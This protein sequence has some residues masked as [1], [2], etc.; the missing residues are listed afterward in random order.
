M[1]R[2]VREPNLTTPQILRVS[3]SSATSSRHSSG[4][5]PSQPTFSK[6]ASKSRIPTASQSG[7]KKRA[8]LGERTDN[9]M[10]SESQQSCPASKP[11]P[12]GAGKTNLFNSPD[13]S[14][15]SLSRFIA[16]SPQT[17]ASI[18]PAYFP[19]S[20]PAASPNAT[21]NS[22]P[23][24]TPYRPRPSIT[25]NMDMMINDDDTLL[26]NMRPPEMD[27]A[28]PRLLELT[29]A[30]ED[31]TS[32]PRVRGGLMTP[33][34]SQEL[35]RGS[36]QLTQTVKR[37]PSATRLS[38]QIRDPVSRFPTPPSS[39]SDDTRMGHIPPATS[40]TTARAS[41]VRARPADTPPRRV[42]TEPSA[43]LGDISAE[44]DTPLRLGQDPSPNP[45]RKKSP[46][47][48]E[49]SGQARSP[50]PV[51]LRS[52]FEVRDRVEVVIP[53]RVRGLGTPKAAPTAITVK[54]KSKGRASTSRTPSATLSESTSTKGSTR[55]SSAGS[56]RRSSGGSQRSVT[57]ATPAQT[58]IRAIPATA[59]VKSRRR[60]TATPSVPNRS[61]SQT[62][63]TVQARSRRASTSATSK[64]P[65]G[66]NSKSVTPM[67]QAL[68]GRKLGFLPRPI[69]GSPGD[70]PL[71][72]KGLDDVRPGHEVRDGSGLGLD[73]NRESGLAHS[74]PSQT[75]AL[76]TGPTQTLSVSSFAS[77]SSPPLPNI[78]RSED[79]LT[80][81]RLADNSVGF[82]D[83]GP[84]WSDDGSDDEGVGEDTFVH[85]M[86]KRNVNST[87]RSNVE[88]TVVE[89][90]E[91]QQEKI[92]EE[93]VPR[94]SSPLLPPRVDVTER[95]SSEELGDITQDAESA[96][97]DTSVDVSE[98]PIVDEVSTDE[99]SVDTPIM[100][101]TND[102]VS[103]QQRN[104]AESREV[105]L[106]IPESMHPT[107]SIGSAIVP[108][109]ESQA[110][111][112]TL[113]IGTEIDD[114]TP[115]AGSSSTEALTTDLQAE[116]ADIS[117]QNDV[118]NVS[119]LS[120]ANPQLAVNDAPG[121]SE[122]PAL[123]GQSS[124]PGTNTRL[125]SSL[126]AECVHEA[127]LAVPS[128]IY[129]TTPHLRS[130]TPTSR[131]DRQ[132]S[133]P[134]SPFV[135]IRHLEEVPP[136]PV[137]IW[138]AREQYAYPVL[139]IYSAVQFSSPQLT[140]E[141]STVR[142]KD[143][144]LEEADRVLERLST[145]V[146]DSVPIV[147][148]K[149]LETTSPAAHSGRPAA[150]VRM[151][152]RFELWDKVDLPARMEIV[153][154][155]DVQN[156]CEPDDEQDAQGR[157]EG[158]EAELPRLR[159]ARSVSLPFVEEGDD[160]GSHIG[161]VTADDEGSHVGD[162][163]ADA[164]SDAW[165]TTEGV[166][167]IGGNIEDRANESEEDGEESQGAEADDEEGE[168]IEESYQEQ[169]Q[170]QHNAQHGTDHSE[171]MSHQIELK[172]HPEYDDAT[173]G[174]DSSLPVQVP[175]RIVLRLVEKGII[176]LEPDVEHLES[177]SES[178][179][180]AP[181]SEDSERSP[182]GVIR[183]SLMTLEPGPSSETLQQRSPEHT[184]RSA[185]PNVTDNVQDFPLTTSALTDIFRPYTPN[186]SPSDA[187]GT[188][189]H[190]QQGNTGS[191]KLS[192][193]IT[194]I[195]PAESEQQSPSP[196]GGV[197]DETN[198]AAAEEE[199]ESEAEEEADRSVVIRAPRRSLYDEI[200]AIAGDVS[201]DEG[202][203]DSFRSV[204]EV[205]SLDPKAAA[206][207]AAILKLN[208][209][210]IEHGRLSS[211]QTE[212]R[213]PS[214]RRQS[215]SASTS[216]HI[217]KQEL[218]HEAEL[219]I[220]AQRR[221]RSRSMS[222]A[223]SESVFSFA[224]DD[225]PVPG[226]YV[227]TP[228]SSGK[229]KRAPGPVLAPHEEVPTIATG[230]GKVWGISEWKKLEKVY[231][232][233]KEEWTKEREV[234]SLPSGLMTWAR[235]STFGVS[236]IMKE[237]DVNRVVEK[238]LA[239]EGEHWDRET[240]LL[241]AQAIERRVNRIQHKASHRT[242]ADSSTT[243]GDNETPRK[244]IRQS[245]T[246][247]TFEGN[248]T[249][250]QTPKAVPAGTV[251][252]E[253]PSTIRRMLGFVWG[254]GKQKSKGRGLLGDL[255]NASVAGEGNKWS[256][257]KEVI[258]AVS[259]STQTILP[260]PRNTRREHEGISRVTGN[261]ETIPPA[262]KAPRTTTQAPS[263]Q[264]FTNATTSN[265]RFSLPTPSSN[266][267]SS[268]WP[269]F[270]SLTPGPSTGKLYPPL[271]PSL[272]QRS[273][274]LAKV[275]PETPTS[276]QRSPATSSRPLGTEQKKRG[277]S[278][279]DLVK[280]FEGKGVIVNNRREESA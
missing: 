27:F 10:L 25:M 276:S 53:V 168:A 140:K 264:V 192:Q 20:S 52:P 257:V 76:S 49:L 97:W 19:S 114:A 178:S 229:R 7:T 124:S 13:R 250:L 198:A 125:R 272:K 222:R 92:A 34:N 14:F 213:T 142:D 43:V 253:P 215:A 151:S 182:S 107:S 158:I 56:N 123:A 149:V 254:G 86:Q 120:H 180:H 135:L 22:F 5:S 59:P 143:S 210:Y 173:H 191:S 24:H 89:E 194:P 83:T 251:G 23:G 18:R 41:R 85:V 155:D 110:P 29:V 117:S 212:H 171:A 3:T 184:T 270:S 161:D 60:S 30:S 130:P 38:T 4:G 32:G 78:S 54:A 235:R 81:L 132:P 170:E 263:N 154:A 62:P 28:S 119:P 211:A 196:F 246:D 234:K 261:T 51:R 214:R 75:S 17:R 259:T 131:Y 187:L 244:R 271:E 197:E 55:R 67:F 159:R 241:R 205:S 189:A 207:A 245:D 202:G 71:L 238:F 109:E 242:L 230:K 105:V 157:Q 231:R 163:T 33:A 226:G 111:V 93:D 203:D 146:A 228:Q 74:S 90:D 183:E 42:S 217:D 174:Q 200:A 274:A 232:K 96:L 91:G 103:E 233:E 268:S 216:R 65:R 6:N 166:I 66:Q 243:G 94:G 31:D 115:L 275:F 188:S 8:V 35:Q 84:A 220:V 162:V 126:P 201:E 167:V 255:E 40:A 239:E 262:P 209:S 102:F 68:S 152:N 156:D 219:D 247:E 70:D 141:S 206:R 9:I 266:N 128:P 46:R 129:E 69:H 144:L 118:A 11:K 277:G 204:V 148:T 122:E 48:D 134:R 175:E 169:E 116:P 80:L 45:R 79:N 193:Q 267:S 73:L 252:V 221:S 186:A 37:T 72:L 190:S 39:Q 15:G 112:Q 179:E 145:P 137:P 106:Q 181:G 57:K 136:T 101:T 113:E 249:I 47:L 61:L 160:E 12:K 176:K 63:R 185:S 1:V 237:W 153:T 208:H 225:F 16:K 50:A 227:R 121:M 147:Q 150:N 279:K 258:P 273:S 265:S 44:W 108:A 36:P 87:I 280:D 98:T 224:T 195:A 99:Q 256:A 64:T 77:R 104:G 164:V 269:T 82:Y 240:I 95:R 236:A 260:P 100:E 26:L 21:A 165:D 172:Q 248:S 127:G 199:S 138:S 223:R 218:L 177:P 133:M 139:N 2:T 88:E 58:R 278:V